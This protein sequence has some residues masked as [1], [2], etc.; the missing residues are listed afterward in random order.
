M[1][2]SLPPH[3]VWSTDK[4]DLADPFQ[5]KWYIRQVLLHGRAQDMGVLDLKE[6]ACLLDE[7]NLPSHLHQ[8]WESFLESRRA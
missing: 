1:Q 7:L 6:I 5:R 4:V 8:L 3:V 2:A